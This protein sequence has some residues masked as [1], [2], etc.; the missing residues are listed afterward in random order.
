MDHGI[1][2]IHTYCALFVLMLLYY[3]MDAIGGRLHWW[4]FSLAKLAMMVYVFIK[5]DDLYGD[6]HPG[7]RFLIIPATR[8]KEDIWKQQV[9]PF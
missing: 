2:A 6:D 4:I 5:P 1:F 7:Y 9:M 3:T 8:F